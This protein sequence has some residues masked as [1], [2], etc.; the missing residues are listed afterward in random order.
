M[1]LC[2]ECNSFGL[3][4]GGQFLLKGKGLSSDLLHSHGLDGSS[5]LVGD[6]VLAV[7]LVQDPLDFSPSVSVLHSPLNMLS[8]SAS[9]LPDHNRL[10]Y[11]ASPNHGLLNY[12]LLV[13]SLYNLACLVGLSDYLLDVLGME[14]PLHLLLG[15]SEPFSFGDVFVGSLPGVSDDSISLSSMDSSLSLSNGLFDQSLGL[16]VR[17]LSFAD[18]SLGSSKSTVSKLG[19]LHCSLNKFG[20]LSSRFH[21]LGFDNLLLGRLDQIH[22]DLLRLM[23]SNLESMSS[24]MGLEGFV[25]SMFSLLV[26]SPH[27]V[28]FGLVT[29]MSLHT[30]HLLHEL[31]SSLTVGDSHGM[32]DVLTSNSLSMSNHR[33]ITV[34][35]SLS[36][37][38]CG[39]SYS[40]A[41]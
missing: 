35:P 36:Q 6:L 25:L 38:V 14:D 16:N 26:K 1:T 3:S 4:S 24:L 39:V 10:R 11:S 32:S 23:G 22:G 34:S 7:R 2:S 20:S 29:G 30:V 28:G 40:L 19:L 8:S 27:F 33:V 9:C 17:S 41:S 21:L 18:L 5:L 12:T 37:V 13:G 15:M 31:V